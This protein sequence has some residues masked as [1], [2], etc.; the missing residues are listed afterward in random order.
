MQFSRREFSKI[1]VGAGALGLLE[2]NG[3]GRFL[4][5]SKKSMRHLVTQNASGERANGQHFP[6]GS[7]GNYYPL[8]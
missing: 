8:S 7:H 5:D 1:L 3:F 6:L 2:V 4:G